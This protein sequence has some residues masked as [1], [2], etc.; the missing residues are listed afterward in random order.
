M[1]K[2][3]KTPQ[4]LSGQAWTDN[5]S[6]PDLK[7]WSE[8]T[9]LAWKK[10]ATADQLPNVNYIV[11]RYITNQDT[12]QMLNSCIRKRY[13]FSSPQGQL[14][15]APAWENRVKFTPDMDD[16]IALLGTPNGKG[17][18]WFM[19]QHQSTLGKKGVVSITVWGPGSELE[20]GVHAE[21][22]LGDCRCCCAG[23]EL[24]GD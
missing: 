7:N 21:H 3:K 8:L 12:V 9:W 22:D 2:S 4:Q 10:L 11:R 23:N 20:Y 5:D 1:I 24:R 19:V 16:F 6:A 13:P 15:R 14:G 18:G 17:V